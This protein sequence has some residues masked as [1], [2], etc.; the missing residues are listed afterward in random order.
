MDIKT[1]TVYKI[2][3]DNS[4]LIYVDICKGNFDSFQKNIKSKHKRSIQDP[5]LRSNILYDHPA[6]K[7]MDC[8]DWHIVII[9]QIQLNI[10]EFRQKK[11]ELIDTGYQNHNSNEIIKPHVRIIYQRDRKDRKQYDEKYREAQR[12]KIRQKAKEIIHCP[13]GTTHTRSNTYNHSL[14]LTHLNFHGLR[15]NIEAITE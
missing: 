10:L 13:C 3:S 11:K 7:I 8:K 2:M 9:Q 1:Y 12:E 15:M 6:F 14:T 5:S 4:P